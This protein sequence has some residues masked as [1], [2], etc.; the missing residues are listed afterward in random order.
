MTR[1]SG[2]SSPTLRRWHY[3]PSSPDP[4]SLRYCE[5]GDMHISSDSLPSHW[6]PYIRCNTA[7]IYN[8]TALYESTLLLDND[9]VEC[10]RHNRHNSVGDVPMRRADAHT[11]T[12]CRG[13]FADRNQKF[14]FVLPFWGPKNI[15]NATTGCWC[16]WPDCSNPCTRNCRLHIFFGWDPNKT[17]P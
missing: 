17:F 11:L 16:T 13:R 8:D 15:G 7:D 9:I 2:C 6:H 5:L 1:S 4:D 12:T 3:S 10:N 14:G